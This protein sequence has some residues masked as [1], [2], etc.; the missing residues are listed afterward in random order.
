LKTSDDKPIVFFDTEIFPNLFICNWK[1]QG[2]DKPIFRMINPTPSEVEQLF[3]YRLIG[4]NNRKYDNHIIYGAYMG[5][6]N[7]SLYELSQKIIEGNKNCFLREAYNIS[8]TDI[9]DFAS[10]GNKNP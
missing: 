1:I 8:Y 4:F 6:D 9:Y 3:K 7:R 2:K 5:Y 10:A